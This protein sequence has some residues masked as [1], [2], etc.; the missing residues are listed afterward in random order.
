MKSLFGLF[1]VFIIIYC[2]YLLFSPAPL[3]EVS[4]IEKNTRETLSETLPAESEVLSA[5][6]GEENTDSRRNEIEKDEGGFLSGAKDYLLSALK[7]YEEILKSDEDGRSGEEDS[8]SQIGKDED[9]S[10]KNKVIA[11]S[12]YEEILGFSNEEDV[13]DE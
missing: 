2:L 4:E 6:N 9:S 1:C 7:D 11:I 5:K 8:N 3:P 10:E 12:I 13:G